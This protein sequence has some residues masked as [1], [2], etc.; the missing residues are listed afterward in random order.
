MLAG[1]GRKRNIINI[2]SLLL[3][4]F[5]RQTKSNPTDWKLLTK[6]KSKKS[7]RQKSSSRLQ[8]NFKLNLDFKNTDLIKQIHT[9]IATFFLEDL[10]GTRCSQKSHFPEMQFV[11]CISYKKRESSRQKGRECN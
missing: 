4:Y 8:I 2:F 6:R 1:R 3:I 10:A 11:V 5:N 9:V 7:Q